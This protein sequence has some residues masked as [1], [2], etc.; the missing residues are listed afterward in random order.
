MAYNSSSSTYN[1]YSV[2]AEPKVK[3]MTDASDF[4]T[5]MDYSVLHEQTKV[6]ESAV[7]QLNN[8]NRSVDRMIILVPSAKTQEVF[9]KLEAKK[10]K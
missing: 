5:M 3:K 8:D 4:P 1:Y 10:D 9:Q 6:G 7:R 2:L